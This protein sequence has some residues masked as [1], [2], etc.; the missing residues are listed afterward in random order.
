MKVRKGGSLC[1]VEGQSW[2]WAAGALKLCRM[3]E[4]GSVRGGE[5]L[6]WWQGMAQGGEAPGEDIQLQLVGRAVMEALI[7]ELW[8][9]AALGH[10]RQSRLQGRAASQAGPGR[11][12]CSNWRWQK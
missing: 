2:S 7:K 9:A 6:G 8:T 1:G 5:D 10:G 11:L 12:H 4:G 3:P